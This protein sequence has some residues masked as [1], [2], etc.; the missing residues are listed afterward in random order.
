MCYKAAAHCFTPDLAQQLVSTCRPVG[1]A[2]NNDR[3]ILAGD[4]RIVQVPQ[5]QRN[6]QVRGRRPGEIV[7]DD[8]GPAFAPGQNA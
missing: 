1:P 6:H 5:Q 3:H 2:T 8:D 7:A 4:A